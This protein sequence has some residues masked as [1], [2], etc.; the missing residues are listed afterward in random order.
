MPLDVTLGPHGI[1]T[2]N[3]NTDRLLAFCRKHKLRVGGSWFPQKEIHRVTWYSN[4]GVTREEIDHILVG[5]RWKL[6][7]SRRVYRS[8]EFS[9]DHRHVVATLRLHLRCHRPP[10][11]S[12]AKGFDSQ[13]LTDPAV[14]SQYECALEEVLH[15]DPPPSGASV[16]D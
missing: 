9:S 7:M 5:T 1:G 11:L 6:L 16:E 3:D 8:F 4:D 15:S 2:S 12:G 10:C 14:E 13:R